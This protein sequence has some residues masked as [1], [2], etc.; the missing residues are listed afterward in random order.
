[1]SAALVHFVPQSPTL[2]SLFAV[3][4]LAVCG[5]V[6]WVLSARYRHR[7]SIIDAKTREKVALREQD[8]LDALT[9]VEQ[10]RVEECI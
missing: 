1:M 5:S 9:R 3:L 10:P 2:W 7:A 8:R 4:V 6:A